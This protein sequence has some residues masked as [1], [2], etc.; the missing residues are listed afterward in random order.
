MHNG[1]VPLAKVRNQYHHGD[2]ESALVATARKLTKRNGVEHL[3]LRKVAQEIGVSPSATYHYFPD[4]D[5]LLAAVGFSLF[6]ELADYQERELAKIIGTTAKAAKDRF[7]SLGMTYFEWA[8]KEPHFFN[9]MF[10]EYCLMGPNSEHKR[11]DSRA[12]LNLTKCLD[13]LVSTGSLDER[14]RQHSE[15]L[16]WTVVHGATSLIV[17]GHLEQDRYESILEDLEFSLGIRK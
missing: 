14:M 4:R 13:E 2:L 16:S 9:L 1:G 7:R 10:S 12:Y 8:I 15:L 5:A 3:S 6:E 17:S 11:E